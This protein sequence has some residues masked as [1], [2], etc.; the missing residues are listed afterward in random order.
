M[1]RANFHMA[2]H[3]YP[4]GEPEL[5]LL[6]AIVH[7]IDDSPKSPWTVSEIRSGV[8]VISGS[9]NHKRDAVS[10]AKRK[11]SVECGL[12][13]NDRQRRFVEDWVNAPQNPTAADPPALF[14][15]GGDSDE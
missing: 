4:K 14:A 5:T 15:E 9:Y 7:R 2:T 3:Q 8:R 12:A 1:K 13:Y 11:C 10:E 6:N